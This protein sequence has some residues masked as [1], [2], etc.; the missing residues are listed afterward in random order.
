MK[1]TNK[2][3]EHFLGSD[4]TKKDELLEEIICLL[5]KDVD[6]DEYVEDVKDY[7]KGTKCKQ[8]IRK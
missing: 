3:L 6:V 7:W 8:I 1:I 4:H 2:H 5:N